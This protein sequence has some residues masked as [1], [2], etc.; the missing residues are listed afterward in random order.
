MSDISKSMADYLETPGRTTLKAYVDAN[1]SSVNAYIRQFD[2]ATDATKNL[3]KKFQAA[4]KSKHPNR[5]RSPDIKLDIEEAWI[6]TKVQ[7][8]ANI[9]TSRVSAALLKAGGKKAVNLLKK[10]PPN[11]DETTAHVPIEAN[12][13]CNPIQPAGPSYTDISNAFLSPPTE[14]AANTSTAETNDT[15]DN[16]NT[17][18]I[19]DN[20]VSSSNVEEE[21]T[22]KLL[23]VLTED[24]E[25]KST[26]LINEDTPECFKRFREFQ[27]ESFK[28]VKKKGLFINRDLF[29]ILSLYNI[30]L[31][32]KNHAYPQIDFSMINDELSE[33][34]ES[35]PKIEKSIFME[36]IQIFRDDIRDR[37]ELKISLFDLYKKANKQD[38]RVIDVMINL[39]NKLPNEEIKEHDIEEQ[40]LIV[41]YTDPIISPLLH[42]PGHDKLFIWLNRTVLQNYE[43][44]PDAGCVALKEKRLDHYVGFA[45]VKPDYKK[46]DTVKTHEDLLRLSLFGMNA[47]EEHNSK[48][49]LLMQV[50]GSSMYVHGCFNRVEGAVVIVELE[51]FKLPMSLKDLPGFI[52]SLDKLKKVGHFYRLQCFGKGGN[53]RR[54]SSNVNLDDIINCHTPKNMKAAV[55]F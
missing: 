32:K 29:Q 4:F 8:T 16:H 26:I 6:E 19:N 39:L 3:Q 48:C 1:Q 52:M 53:K 34:F 49:I 42:D 18:I 23:F 15:A 36:I 51:E 21:N 44:R 5:K 33:E 22:E 50:I 45:E 41:N 27:E 37:D 7:R 25:F 46:K 2:N 11:S 54:A 17:N 47:L 43:K 55:D 28:I 9:Q 24:E 38:R 40:E 12:A 20:V 31:L 14:P 35:S 10:A 13:V 30:V